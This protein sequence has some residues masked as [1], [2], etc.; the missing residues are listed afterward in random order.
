MK[1][2]VQN[3][4]RCTTSAYKKILFILV[5]FSFFIF[6]P[7]LCENAKFGARILFGIFHIL[8][9]LFYLVQTINSCLWSLY[10][11]YIICQYFYYIC[12]CIV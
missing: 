5:S 2:M 11:I 4:I 12:L 1:N 8:C 7:S 10:Y 9:G 3:T 6:Q